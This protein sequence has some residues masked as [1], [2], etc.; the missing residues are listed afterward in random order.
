MLSDDAS[1]SRSARCCS[2]T[3][4]T[5]GPVSFFRFRD[6]GRDRDTFETDVIVA[7]RAA[8]SRQA[9]ACGQRK[10]K[11][12]NDFRPR[13]R[14]PTRKVP[15]PRWRGLP[16]RGTSPSITKSCS[17]H[18]PYL[19]T[20]CSHFHLKLSKLT[21]IILINRSTKFHWVSSTNT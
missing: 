10:R 7:S 4:T 20:K 8:W 9:D 17:Q 18:V 5:V 16:Q 1:C 6:S 14:F 12:R 21:P 15:L 19:F 11:T 2:R 13:F 3:R